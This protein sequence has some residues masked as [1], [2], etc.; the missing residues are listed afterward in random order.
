MVV[1]D[2]V[3]ASSFVKSGLEANKAERRDTV[4]KFSTVPPKS[5]RL[6]PMLKGCRIFP[7][8]VIGDTVAIS[9]G[10]YSTG[11]PNIRTK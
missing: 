7:R 2:T 4:V 6:T 11:T 10:Y 5:G 8:Q 9:V 1:H 3:A